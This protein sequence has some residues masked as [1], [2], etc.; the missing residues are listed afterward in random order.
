MRQMVPSKNP[1]SQGANSWVPMTGKCEVV[2]KSLRISTHLQRKQMA[3]KHSYSMD[4][5]YDTH[6]ASKQSPTNQKVVACMRYAL[7]LSNFPRSKHHRN[8]WACSY[9]NCRFARF[10]QWW[11]LMLINSSE[12]AVAKLLL[13]HW[14]RLYLTLP[15]VFPPESSGLPDSHCSP[16]KVRH[17]GCSPGGLW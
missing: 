7:F 4:P 11:H 1:W 13:S 2:P 3:E 17:S 5:L 8:T 6:T 16:G 10:V 15:L 14:N 9:P 12:W